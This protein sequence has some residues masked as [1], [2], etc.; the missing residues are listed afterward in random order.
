MNE[1][2]ARPRNRAVTQLIHDR[3]LD[4]ELAALLWLLADAHVPIV[5]M[6]SG[7]PAPAVE[8]RSAIDALSGN[9]SMTVDGAMPGGV[10]HGAS[11]ED[12]LAAPGMRFATDAHDHEHDHG[13]DVPDEAR[14]LGVVLI[15]G[16]PGEPGEPSEAGEPGDDEA[17]AES[18][19]PQI[20]R[21][22]YVR[23]IERDQAGHLQRRPPTLLSAADE[24]GALDHFFWAIN[25]ELSMRTEMGSADFEREHARRAV[26]LRDLVSAHVFDSQ[27]LR[28][29]IAAMGLVGDSQRD[30]PN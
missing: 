6:V 29:Q 25:D 12:A 22:H 28:R 8:I 1:T 27:S 16:Q 2:S 13:S 18:S 21:A 3:V 26:V 5:V 11:L 24:T 14:D 23:P 19:K 9:M 20:V 30:G 17:P 15:L 10:L 4:P 7:D